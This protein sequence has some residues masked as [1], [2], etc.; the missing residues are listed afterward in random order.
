MS[1][2]PREANEG[3]CQA[4]QAPGKR[5]KCVNCSVTHYCDA[6]C[7]RKDWP[8]HKTRCKFLQNH[9]PVANAEPQPIPC[10]IIHGGAIRYADTTLP[11]THDIFNTRALPITL[12]FD[13]PLVMSRVVENLPIGSATDNQHATWLNIDPQTGFAPPHWQGGIGN[14]IVA[15][16]DGTPLNTE[17]LSAIVDYVSGI[18]DAFG[19]TGGP[20]RR[21]Y[22]RVLL[23]T[24]IRRHLDDQANYQSQLAA[25]QAGNMGGI[26]ASEME[27]TPRRN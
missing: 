10:V 20:P 19:D 15:N 5:L 16:S 4:C 2:A 23:D 18:L 12:K 9:P 21:N 1:T 25:F 7:Q 27:Q 13:Y 22:N 11:S 14:V 6:T 17:T 8:I 3:I 26:R 24:Y